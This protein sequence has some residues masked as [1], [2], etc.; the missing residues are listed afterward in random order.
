MTMIL[1]VMNTRAL[2]MRAHKSSSDLTSSILVSG[3]PNRVR[4][5]RR[6]H[7]L[8]LIPALAAPFL[9]PRQFTVRNPRILNVLALFGAIRATHPSRI[10]IRSVSPAIH[11]FACRV[12]CVR[13]NRERKNP[14]C[15]SRVR[16]T[17][18]GKLRSQA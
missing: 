15:D 5:D 2:F 10:S 8:L 14:T 9:M 18:G 11:S 6:W 4:T 1:R 17:G 12:K 3:D 13:Q 16:T 7:L